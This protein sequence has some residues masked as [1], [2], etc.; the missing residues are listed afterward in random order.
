MLIAMAYVMV[1]E[2]LYDKDF[3]ERYTIGFEQYKNYL[4]GAEDRVLKTPAWAEEITGVP[5]ATTAPYLFYRA[6]SVP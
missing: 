4:L 1:Q 5:A 6:V 3:V 2:G